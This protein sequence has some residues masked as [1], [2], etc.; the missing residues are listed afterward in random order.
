V[1]RPLTDRQAEM[2]ERMATKREPKPTPRNEIKKT[3]QEVALQATPE[4]HTPRY[5]EREQG[6]IDD[7]LAAKY[8]AAGIETSEIVVRKNELRSEL[9]AIKQEEGE[10][11][12]ISAQVAKVRKELVNLKTEFTLDVQ[13][14]E[15]AGLSVEE[16][17]ELDR[18]YEESTAKLRS[19][20]ES[21]D[22]ASKKLDMMSGKGYKH[23]GPHGF[24]SM[25]WG[26]GT[27]NDR[28][29]QCGHTLRHRIHVGPSVRWWKQADGSY[30]AVRPEGGNDLGIWVVLG[31][32]FAALVILVLWALVT[33][34]RR[35]DITSDPV[36]EQVTAS[37]PPPAPGAHK[38]GHHK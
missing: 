34:G 11:D 20:S 8:A 36:Q 2:R 18:V 23:F 10:E 37:A 13:E 30:G 27:G 7:R 21:L 31:V 17:E 9:N 29:L 35:T 38:K 14:C 16:K 5:V 6:A 15:Q 22:A 25:G 1:D 4:F 26:H 12:E 24:A 32:I 28:C 19:M 33:Y 3:P